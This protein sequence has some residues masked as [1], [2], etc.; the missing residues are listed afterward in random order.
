MSTQGIIDRVLPFCPGWQRSSGRKNL[1]K[2]LE[3]ALDD[4]FDYDHDCM[5]YRGTDNQG[6]PP[7]LY[8]TAGVY[9]YSVSAA[10]LSCGAITRSIG[11]TDYTLTARKVRRVFIDTTGMSPAY[12]DAW[13]GS[14]YRS[15]LNPYC[16]DNQTRIFIADIRIQSQP[17]YEN[18]SPTVK[19]QSDPGTHND[20]YFIEFFVGPPRLPSENIEVPIPV[21]F[22]KDFESYIIGW[23]QFRENGKMNDSLV[24]FEEV[25]KP[26]FREEF[27]SA[28]SIEEKHTPIRIC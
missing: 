12:F 7:Y 18:T 8:T 9:D 27:G 25:F 13:T 3:Q 22:E 16:Y 28:A 2:V 4:A 24:Y 26:K 17:S 11:G 19:F 6:F 15:I 5:V 21:S 14:P 1:L 20:K 10:Y 23:V